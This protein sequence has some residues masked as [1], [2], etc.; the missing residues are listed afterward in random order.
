MIINAIVENQFIQKTLRK[1]IRKKTTNVKKKTREAD[2]IFARITRYVTDSPNN[3]AQDT[4]LNE[5][6]CSFIQPE[7]HAAAQKKHIHPSRR[8]H[9]RKHARALSSRTRG[10]WPW[11]EAQCRAAKGCENSS[12]VYV[13][14]PETGRACV[15]RNARSIFATWER[16]DICPQ[17]SIVSAG[18][19][20]KMMIDS[21][22]FA[23]WIELVHKSRFVITTSRSIFK[24]NFCFFKIHSRCCNMLFEHNI[25]YTYVYQ[26]SA[27]NRFQF[28]LYFH[29]CNIL[30]HF[31]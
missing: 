26:N 13:N 27:L 9:T 10:Q 5:T 4:Q 20:T 21:T 28:V 29:D 17:H 8:A 19:V 11:G 23:N 6:V 12:G 30:G 25:F 7:T 2:T 16:P 1:S 14:A 18:V 15:I 3:R 24:S 31:L 22:H